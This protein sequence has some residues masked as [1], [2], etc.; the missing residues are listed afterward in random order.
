MNFARL[1]KKMDRI[2][3]PIHL[4]GSCEAEML[5]FTIAALCFFSKH[6]N[7][8]SKKICKTIF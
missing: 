2:C 6:K 5:S 7:T 4:G 3:R 1:E 8:K